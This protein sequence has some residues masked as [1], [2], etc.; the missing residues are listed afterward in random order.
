MP[1][2]ETEIGQEKGEP[3]RPQRV[4]RE[5]RLAIVVVHPTINNNFYAFRE[6]PAVIQIR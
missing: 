2:I 6:Q 1:D 5:T 3:P 4:P